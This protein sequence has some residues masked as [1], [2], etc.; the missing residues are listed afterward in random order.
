M[1]RICLVDVEDLIRRCRGLFSASLRGHSAE[2]ILQIVEHEISLLYKQ[3]SSKA[4]GEVFIISTETG[5]C[6]APSNPYERLLR[7]V[8]GRLNQKIAALSNRVIKIDAGIA[9]TIKDNI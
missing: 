5:S 4:A 9:Q 1:L 7:E 6:S 8:N 3:L 2:Q